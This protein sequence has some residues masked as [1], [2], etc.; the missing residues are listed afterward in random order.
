MRDTHSDIYARSRTTRDAVHTAA[1]IV[2]ASRPAGYTAAEHERALDRLL[3]DIDAAD[4]GDASPARTTGHAM[5]EP[6]MHLAS[7]MTAADLFDPLFDASGSLPMIR[8]A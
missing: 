1:L 3:E 4:E 8:I 5:S 7:P 6:K 2:R